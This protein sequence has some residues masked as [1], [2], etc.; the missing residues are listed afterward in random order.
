M[1]SIT[2][3]MPEEIKREMISFPD[4]NWSAV[5]RE[6]IKRRLIMLHKFREF[7]KDSKLTEEEALQLGRE[8]NTKARGK[9]KD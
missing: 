1:V 7:T 3:S 6:A 2:L 5:A 4:I 9:Y 8:L